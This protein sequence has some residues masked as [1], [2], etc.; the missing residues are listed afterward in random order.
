METW[1]DDAGRLDKA[2]EEWE[3][4]RAEVEN[5]NLRDFDKL[6]ERRR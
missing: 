1:A 2:E 5:P 6:L 3:T 4:M